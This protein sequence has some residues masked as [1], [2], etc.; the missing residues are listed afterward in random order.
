MVFD[1]WSVVTV[2][3]F[4]HAAIPA[5]KNRIISRC[6]C[7]IALIRRMSGCIAHMT[8][9]KQ[10][11]P[12]SNS[13]WKPAVRCVSQSA[14][15]KLLP[16]DYDYDGPHLVTQVPGPRSK[17]L[18]E[19]LDSIQNTEAVQFFCDFKKS[20]GNWLVDAD[21]NRLLDVYSQ[22]ASL[23]LG[24]NHPA[25]VSALADESNLSAFANR[26]ALGVLP[27]VD[28]PDTL[29]KLLSRVAP[30]GLSQ[31]QTMACG[32]CAN[33]NAFKAVFFWYRAKQRGSLIHT[34]EELES[35]M[36]HEAPGSPNLSILGFKGGF[37]GRTIG[38]SSSSH[39]APLHK[40]DVP[41]LD[42]P[43]APFPA[44]KYPL[45]VNTQENRQE[46]ERCLDKVFQLMQEYKNKG[47]PVAGVVVEPIQSEGGD[48]HASNN[49]F[50]QLRK[51]AK[52]N[53]SA[54][55]VDEVQTGAGLTGKMWAH[56]YWGLEES[57]DIVTF[58][59][60]MVIGG[61]Y[62]KEEFRP[63]GPF[64]IM[65]TWLG[66]PAK[67]VIMEAVLNVIHKDRL[68]DNMTE[69]GQVILQGLEKLQDKHADILSNARGRGAFCA[70]DFPDTLTRDR[71]V[72]T[73]RNKGVQ[74]AG[75]GVKSLRVRPA[76]I[77]QPHHARMF[78]DIMEETTRELKSLG[79]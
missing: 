23:P 75:C 78:L 57:P 54:F 37:H 59:K 68:L 31:V 1:P 64:R 5:F 21:G 44:T 76:L 65:N 29:Q 22:I 33:E 55:V 17:M 42:W 45:D 53:G 41:A 66:D 10:L 40:V 11:I 51:L 67:L 62:F 71:A 77:F 20:R 50:R 58:S 30:P 36:R 16:D 32:T 14:H 15:R 43:S 38:C 35:C 52:E 47:R 28:F 79:T 6:C 49:F 18:L 34:E 61:L 74:G 24:Y 26:P 19:S 9:L 13:V 48:R 7:R 63:K 70:V 12:R 60:K 69:T 8:V 73:L 4:C 25:I 3:F 27:P 39:A 56:E 46:E 2:L 72:A